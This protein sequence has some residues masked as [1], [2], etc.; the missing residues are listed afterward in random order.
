[1]A[2]SF[3]SFVMRILVEDEE[4]ARAGWEMGRMDEAVG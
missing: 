2:L 3:G 4:V 1:M